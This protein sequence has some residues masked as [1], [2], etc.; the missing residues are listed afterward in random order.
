MG[1]HHDRVAVF[2]RQAAQRVKQPDLRSDVQMERRLIQQQEKWLLRQRARQ[3]DTLFFSAG[4]F[5]H[6][7]VTQLRGADLS[8]S[9]FCDQ[10]VS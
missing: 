9:V 2:S 5:V 6:P 3:D 10:H 8:E 4:N 1:H 7:T